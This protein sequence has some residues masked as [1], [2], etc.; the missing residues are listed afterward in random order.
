MPKGLSALAF[1]IGSMW[2]ESRSIVFALDPH[3]AKV[4]RKWIE[5]GLGQS[6]YGRWIG[7]GLEVDYDRK[8]SIHVGTHWLIE[9]CVCRRCRAVI[10]LY[11]K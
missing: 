6:T 2:I 8:L 10:V 4:D 5:T 3:S 9:A 1:Q 7:S 11:K